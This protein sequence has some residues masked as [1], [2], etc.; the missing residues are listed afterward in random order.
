MTA[1]EITAVLAGITAAAGGGGGLLLVLM[2]R[3][4][5]AMVVAT[6]WCSLARAT[7]CG[8]LTMPLSPSGIVISEAAPHDRDCKRSIGLP[9]RP[10]VNKDG[11]PRLDHKTG[12]PPW[13]PIGEILDRDGRERFQAAALDAIDKLLGGQP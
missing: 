3:A 1:R 8:F 2:D 4:V 9:A 5:A 12:R 10:H 6:G 7:L 13:A 11:T